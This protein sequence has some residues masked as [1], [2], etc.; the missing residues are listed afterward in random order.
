MHL[1]NKESLF[2]CFKELGIDVADE[3][4]LNACNLRNL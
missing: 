1:F 3:E 4:A 2:D